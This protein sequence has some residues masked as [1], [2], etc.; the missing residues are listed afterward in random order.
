MTIRSRPTTALPSI[1][2]REEWQAASERL[3]AR[4][5]AHMR[6]GDALAAERRRL[7][8]VEIEKDYRFQG[9]EGEV[10]LI[11]LFR[12]HRQLILQHFMFGPDWDEGCHG[13]SMMADHIAPLAHLHARGTTYAMVS[14]APLEKLLPFKQRMGW[15][16]PWYSSFGTDFN[17]DFHATVNGEEQQGISTFL[18]DGDRVFHTWWTS[19]RG[20]EAVLGTFHLLDLT[21]L[22]RQ[23][24]WEDSP[25]S[26]PQT[27]PYTWW[28]HHDRYQN[29]A[30][31]SGGGE[32]CH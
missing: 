22:G 11:D 20:A 23:E 6:A 13:C 9:E 10:R 7:P 32:S 16:I 30:G 29:E 17:E 12:G 31:H 26:W 5:K 25:E 24:S 14:R 2:T 8:M 18:R 15:Q 4:E 19:N 28:R 27:E 3:L 21:V 1:V